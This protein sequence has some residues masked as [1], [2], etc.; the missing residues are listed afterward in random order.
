M[1]KEPDEFDAEI[2]VKLPNELEM[3]PRTWQTW[4]LNWRKTS[5]RIRNDTKEPGEFDAE[6]YVNSSK[7]IRYD[8]KEPGEL[9]AEL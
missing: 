9:K 4:Y 8:I 7:R 5:K 3:T 2:D 1:T 6:I